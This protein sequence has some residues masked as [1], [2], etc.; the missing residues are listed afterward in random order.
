[1]LKNK[2]LNSL[3]RESIREIMLQAKTSIIFTYEIL[4]AFLLK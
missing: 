3:H 4:E 2:L 1:M